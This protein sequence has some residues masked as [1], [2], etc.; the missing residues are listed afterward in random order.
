M[1]FSEAR[2]AL[3]YFAVGAS[4]AFDVAPDTTLDSS[5]PAEKAWPGTSDLPPKLQPKVLAARAFNGTLTIKNSLPFDLK[6]TAHTPTS[7]NLRPPSDVKS[8]GSAYALVD[9]GA[10]QVAT[11]SLTVQLQ[12]GSYRF[13]SFLYSVGCVTVKDCTT[14]QGYVSCN[15]CLPEGYAGYCDAGPR[16]T[17]N[18]DLTF[19][20][21][22]TADLKLPSEK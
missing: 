18:A 9:S 6:V 19:H 13:A 10:E 14:A 4:L 3:A 1:F 12:G 20:L 7:G 22:S 5:E 11:G 16:G 2:V 17:A 21:L 8:K 15:I